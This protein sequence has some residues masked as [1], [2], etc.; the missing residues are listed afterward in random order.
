VKRGLDTNVLVY[1]HVAAL[2]EHGAVR[3]FLAGQLARRDVTLFVTPWVLHEFVHV[4][5]DARR[6]EPPVGMG[7]ALALARL[8]LGRANVECV[9][10]DAEALA[11]AFGLV[12]RHRL[13]RKRL[14]DTLLAA[15]L[16]RH[17]VRQ[18]VTCNRSDF[19]VFPGLQVIDPRG[20]AA[21]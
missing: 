16:L 8:Y 11:E 21:S 9:A 5:T 17:G 19:E 4:V 2:P 13:G 12:D 14:A 1:A 20:P 18:L 15:T 10:T 6:F 7:E 3:E